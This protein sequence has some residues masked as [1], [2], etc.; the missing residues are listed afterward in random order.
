MNPSRRVLVAAAIKLTALL[1]LG[2]AVA[3]PDLGGL[4]AKGIGVRAAVYPLGLAALPVIWWL[5]RQVRPQVRSFSWVADVCCS[6]PILVDLLGN[7]LNLFDR[8]WWWDDAMH[9]AMHGL[10]TAGLLLQFGRRADRAQLFLAAAAF[11]GV[12]GLAWELGEYVA[13]MRFGIELSGAYLDTLGDLT[14]GMVGSLLAGAVLVSPWWS[15][16]GGRASAAV[17]PWPSAPS[18]DRPGSGSPRGRL[19]GSPAPTPG[20]ADQSGSSSRS[21]RHAVPGR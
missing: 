4:K 3:W 18:P 12:S 17:P 7:R 1:L 6:L 11:A 19:P 10:L 9:L 20:G 5:A 21:S 16:P 8:I 13:F 15:R 14:L 2:A